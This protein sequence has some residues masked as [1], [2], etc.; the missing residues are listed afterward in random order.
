MNLPDGFQKITDTAILGFFNEYRFLSNFHVHP[1]MID[2]ITYPSNEHAYMAYKTDDIELKKIIA[3]I[4]TCSAVKRFGQTISLRADWDNYRVAAMLN[5]QYQKY[6]DPE[7]AK[8]LLA[9]GDKYLEETNWWG[10]RYWGVQDGVGLN[11]LGKVCMIVRSNLRQKA[12]AI[13]SF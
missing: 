9:T 13:I 6:E 3:K 4:P 10:D 12:N 11:M 5:C 1:I 8:L 2:G 7:L